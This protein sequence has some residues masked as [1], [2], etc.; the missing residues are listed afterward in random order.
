MRILI[1]GGLGFIGS[2][3]IN[4]WMKA[5][6]DMIVNL[7]KVT[8]AA[9]YKNV[10]SVSKMSNYTF[11]RGDIAD[12]NIVNKVAKDVDLIINFAA[13]THV[14]NSIS[15]QSP[16]LRSNIMGTHVLLEAARKYD[17]RIHHISTDEVYGPTNLNS[18]KKFDE[19][20]RYNPKNPYSATKAAADH[21]VNSYFNT[22]GIKSTISNCGNNYGPHQ[23]VEKLIP[24]TIVNTLK[25]ETVPV[26]GSGAQARDWI[27]VGDH[28]RAIDAIINYGKIGETYIVSGGNELRNIDLIRKI[29]NSLGKDPSSVIKFVK[30]RPGHDVRYALSSSKITR[31]LGWKPE[32][33]FEIG[34][35]LTI[36]YY[37]NKLDRSVN[38]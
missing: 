25:N 24:K 7:D 22:Y 32:V 35:E 28:C 37:R 6:S 23:H 19:N 13:E 34:L 30:D 5:H 31:E 29:I 16:F 26:Y 33:P 10:E 3:F 36:N 12:K 21:L 27:Y 15:N 17:I 1:T 8:Y 38:I 11:V 20:S 18:K 9:D 4:Y 2:N 14:D